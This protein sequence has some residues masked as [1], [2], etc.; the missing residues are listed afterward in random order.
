VDPTTLKVLDQ[1]LGKLTPAKVQWLQMTIW[2]R[3]D[4]EDLCYKAEGRFLAAPGQRRCLR[5]AVTVGRT[6]GE[7]E[8]VS[9]GKNLQARSQVGDGTPALTQLALPAQADAAESMLQQHGLGGV[10]TLLQGL[11]DH[12]K[13]PRREVILWGGKEVIRLSGAWPVNAA[14]LASLPDDLPASSVPRHC[15]VYLDSRTLWPLRV[16]WWASGGVLLSQVEFR[17]PAIDHPL[18]QEA[19]A[20]E[21]AFGAN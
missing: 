19:C 12:L 6:R 4:C 15:R 1:A 10:V 14:R 2:Q 5:L 13:Q 11:R 16:E 17:D 3:V 9:T 21:F 18:S 20:R 8:A 7:V